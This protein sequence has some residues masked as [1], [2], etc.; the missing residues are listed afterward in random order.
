MSYNLFLDDCRLPVHCKDYMI[1]RIGMKSYIY[2]DNKNWIVANK[3][4]EF[5]RIINE[6]GIPNMVSFDHDLADEHYAPENRWKDYNVWA[7]EIEFKEKTG[8]DCAKFLVDVCIETKQLFPEFYIH[9]MNPIGGENINN[10][11]KNYIK[12]C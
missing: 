10:Y 2:K 1:P 9:S 4:S 6:K 3:Y 11:I 12:S 7:K 8:L 5:V